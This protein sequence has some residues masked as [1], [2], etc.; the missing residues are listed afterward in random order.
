MHTASNLKKS[1][2][3]KLR[4]RFP[5]T[6]VSPITTPVASISTGNV[7]TCALL[8][9]GLLQC[10]GYDGYNGQATPPTDLGTVVQVDMG[11]A[12]G[13]AVTTAG[14]VRC[15]GYNAEGQATVPRL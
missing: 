11:A 10:F 5:M 1:G 3:L 13:C 14:E 7:V 15:W 6:A 4:T 9:T 2:A 8:D 12:H